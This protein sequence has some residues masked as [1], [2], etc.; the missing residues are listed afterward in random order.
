MKTKKLRKQ[1]RKR[2]NSPYLTMEE[3][4]WVQLEL[5]RLSWKS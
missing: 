5:A 4:L 3:R 1:L 2:L